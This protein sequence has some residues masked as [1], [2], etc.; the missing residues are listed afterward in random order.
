V[1]LLVGDAFVV[2]N[3]QIAIILA[4]TQNFVNVAGLDLGLV[5]IMVLQVLDRL[6]VLYL[7]SLRLAG[8]NAH[9]CLLVEKLDKSI[10]GH[11]FTS[12]NKPLSLNFNII[13][14]LLEVLVQCLRLNWCTHS[15]WVHIVHV[16]EAHSSEFCILIALIKWIF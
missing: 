8:L 12:I 5:E 10:I 6:D 3:F 15:F 13:L 14:D 2:D 1:T 16:G 11:V 9:A 4:V 7:C